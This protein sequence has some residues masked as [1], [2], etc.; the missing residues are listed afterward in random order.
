MASSTEEWRAFLI[1]AKNDE[2]G[3]GCADG[4]QDRLSVVGAGR[5]EC[6]VQDRLLPGLMLVG[7]PTRGRGDVEGFRRPPGRPEPVIVV[8]ARGWSTVSFPGMPSLSLLVA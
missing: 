3:G 4:W 5:N 7:R 6:R 1:G 8:A 2:V